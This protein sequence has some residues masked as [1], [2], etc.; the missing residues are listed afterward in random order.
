MRI[1]IVLILLSL[2]FFSCKSNNNQ[3]SSSVVENSS[4]IYGGNNNQMIEGDTIG[5]GSFPNDNLSKSVTGGLPLCLTLG[6][7]SMYEYQKNVDMMF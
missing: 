5:S 2:F 1:N 7:M 6:S 4:I 3:N